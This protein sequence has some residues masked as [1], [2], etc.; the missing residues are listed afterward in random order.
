MGWGLGGEDSGASYAEQGL[1]EILN[2]ASTSCQ[3][4]TV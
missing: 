2:Q 4:S 3:R 1:D